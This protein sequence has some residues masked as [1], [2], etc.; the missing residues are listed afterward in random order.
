MPHIIAQLNGF[1]RYAWVT[2]A[3]LLTSTIAVPI[4]GKLSDL[5]ERKWIYLGGAVFFV[6]TSALCGAA[7]DIPLP[8]DGMYQ[9]ILFRGLQGLAA[10]VVTGL[11]FTIRRRH[12]PPRRARQVPGTLLRRLGAGL[13]LRPDPRRLD[14]R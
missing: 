1:E 14:H 10:G 13:G 9:L 7:G 8:L 2:T 5:Y 6:I 3:Y 4:F 12:L 11:T